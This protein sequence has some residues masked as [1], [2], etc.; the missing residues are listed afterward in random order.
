MVCAK[1]RGEQQTE[2]SLSI[3]NLPGLDHL[4]RSRQ[5][6]GVK[7]EKFVRLVFSLARDQS[8]C[9]IDMDFFVRESGRR[10]HGQEVVQLLSGTASFFFEL[11]CSTITWILS[12]I[13]PSSRNLK[14][15]TV[16]RISVLSDQEY[17]RILTARVAQERHNSAR[18]RMPYHLE[19]AG[20]AI[21]ETN[22]VHVKR[23][24]LPAIH[25]LRFLT[26]GS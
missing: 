26:A 4:Q 7:F 12:W 16:C 19:L 18:S 23:D 13:E 25:A 9:H 24:D 22:S 15:V 14:E 8:G 1:P 11:A 17:L 10:I 2:R 5:E 3:P 20:R 6:G 21:R